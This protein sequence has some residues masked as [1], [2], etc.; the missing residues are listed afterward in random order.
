MSF[1]R[2]AQRIIIILSPRGLCFSLVEAK[3]RKRY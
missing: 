2:L 1:Q 3:T